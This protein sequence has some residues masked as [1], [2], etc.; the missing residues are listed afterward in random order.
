MFEPRITSYMR[1]WT[2][3]SQS[4]TSNS[5]SSALDPRRPSRNQGRDGLV[6]PDISPARRARSAICAVLSRMRLLM[7]DALRR[8]SASNRPRV[9]WIASRNSRKCASQY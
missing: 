2:S 7:L 6:T 8:S 4:L 9:G 1:R 5:A 3:C